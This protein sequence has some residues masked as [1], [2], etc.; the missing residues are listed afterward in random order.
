VHIDWWTLVLQTLNVLI[1][2][3]LLGRF[4]FRPVT[5]IVARRQDEAKKL[6]ADAEAVGRQAEAARADVD[7]ARSEMDARRLE[8][9]DQAQKEAKAEKAR[10]VEEAAQQATEMREAAAATAE[11][12]RADAEGALLQHAGELSLEIAQR[13]LG[14][15]P[16]DA[17]LAAFTEGL[18][19]EIRALPPEAR[20]G[21]KSTAV[22]GESLE[23]WSASG[24]SSE[25]QRLVR[26]RLAGV[27][28]YEPLIAF[29]RNEA[30]MAGLELRGPTTIVRNNWRSDL[31]RIRE[32]LASEGRS[33]KV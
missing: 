7:K 24:L 18:C 11:R 26:E 12:D 30:L 25:Q 8:L 33:R 27:L 10:L 16:A 6:L 13:L 23:L 15:L 29:H 21:L 4:F 5:A 19:R 32:E 22:S 14:R 28:G 9:L 2:V 17:G 20:A 1:L 31:D 3:W